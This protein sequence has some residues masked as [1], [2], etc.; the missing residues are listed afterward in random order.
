MITTEAGG[1][2]EFTVVLNSEPTANVT[3]TLYSSD[4]DEGTPD[5]TTL[6][7]TPD[8]WDAPQTVTVTGQ[9]DDLDD[10]NQTYT[11]E[12]EPATSD[13]EDYQG[14]DGTDVELSNTDDETAGI[15]VDPI[16]DLITT[17]AGGEAEFTVV[18][19]SEPTA[20]VT[21]TLYSSDED[22][23]TL[24]ETTLLFTSDDWD[25]PQTVTVTGQDDDLD[26]GNQTY[27]IEVEPAT[28]DD[29]DYQGE[30]G[31]DVELSNTDDENGRHHRRSDRGLDHHRS[32]RRGR[33][34]RRP[35]LRA[36]RQRHHHA[37]QQ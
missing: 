36:D 10:G 35:Q 28:S 26:D 15:T 37:L 2:A 34:H 17:E 5:E 25:T 18:L 1:E 23:G 27:T 7:F 30:D 13:D 24:D 14:E 29:E 11:I 19:N 31:T 32:W 22:E 16:E 20:N 9:D 21:I 8:D 12:V 4:E 6:L 3:I 33:V